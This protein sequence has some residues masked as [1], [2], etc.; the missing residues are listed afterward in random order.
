M[1]QNLFGWKSASGFPISH[2]PLSHH[3]KRP[4]VPSTRTKQKLVQSFCFILKLSPWE[5]TQSAADPVPATAR[6]TGLHALGEKECANVWGEWQVRSPSKKEC[7]CVCV[8]VFLFFPW[9]FI[10]LGLGWTKCSFIYLFSKFVYPHP[11]TFFFPLLFRERGRE[12][13]TLIGCL[14]YIPRPGIVLA[15]TEGSN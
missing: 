12:R 1:W 15:Q 10:S 8:S 3:G 6:P 13:E 9:D 4:T 11:R 7:V 5:L 14:P 2:L